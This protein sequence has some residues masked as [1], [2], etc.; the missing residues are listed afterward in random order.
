MALGTFV[1]VLDNTIMNVSI[2]AL[3]QDLNTTV[4]GVQTAIALNALMMAAFVLF[5]GKLA[6]I[7][8]MKK[9]FMTGVL[10]YIAGSLTASFSNNLGVFI[11]GWC[12]IQ[13]FGAAMML[14]NVQTLIRAVLHGEARAKA[15]GAMAA[16]NAIAAALGPVIGGFLTTYFSWR[17][18]F[19]MEV[20]FLLF[21]LVMNHYIPKDKAI[22][23]KV[24][25][26]G[27]GLVLQAG[28]MVS[29]VLGILM[30]SDYG[31]FMAKQPVIINGI[32]ITE[33]G[34]GLSPVVWL[35]GL[36]L[37]LLMLFI[38][39]ENSKL[40][41]GKPSLVHVAL[42]KIRDFV[43]GLKVRSMQVFL[44]AGIL[45]S[46]PLFLQVTFEISAFETG[47]ALLPLS[48]S[49][50]IGSFIGVRMAKKYLPK[51]IVR[52]GALIVMAGSVILMALVT[53]S[54]EPAEI[55]LGLIVFGFGLALIG[56]QI[57][58]LIL[59]SVT[60]KET[61]EASGITSTLEQLGNSLGVAILGSVLVVALSFSL[62]QQLNADTSLPA[63][64]REKAQAAV[65]DGVEIL[66]N[67]QIEEQLSDLDPE[68][69]EQVLQMYDSARTN[70]FRVTMLSVGFIGL[71][72]F[73][74]AASLPERKLVEGMENSA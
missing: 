10:I 46:M 63:D 18:A 39:V 23:K 20:A 45:F 27:W 32:N 69:E 56:S 2:Q 33:M 52:L 70:A 3:V 8:G 37:V 6:D 26:D 68:V 7:I 59:S 74:T 60:P 57:V 38:H 72:M 66:S 29:I 21:I 4:T 24:G 22:T 54:S 71:L 1:V 44:V 34:L 30:I 36:G 17:W 67:S 62:T 73:I 9:T 41:K 16:V 42:F 13:G 15:Y 65:N 49:L 51:N 19:R 14:P 12:L 35:V 28:A 53:N 25:I 5:G 58:N 48:I 55:G 40:E 43:T 11:L 31:A 50:V 61:A 64:I 47:L